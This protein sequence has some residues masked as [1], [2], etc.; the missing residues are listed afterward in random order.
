M[1]SIL[2]G[3]SRSPHLAYP[4]SF[5]LTICLIVSHC[6]AIERDS[7]FQAEGGNT[8]LRQSARPS[9]PVSL[10]R[11]MRR[12]ITELQQQLSERRLAR[13]IRSPTD[14]VRRLKPRLSR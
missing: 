7:L 12:T 9:R 5:L 8:W 2:A 13:L 14:S 1:T 6:N 11:Q 3:I 4:T 10:L